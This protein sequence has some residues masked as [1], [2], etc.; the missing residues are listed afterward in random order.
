MD[1]WFVHGAGASRRSFAWLSERLDA[2]LDDG[3]QSV[4]FEH[5]LDESGP[6]ALARLR[7][8]LDKASAPVLLF[9]HSL[10]GLLAVPASAS[11]QV[12]R[13]VTLSAP[14]RGVAMAEMLR[15]FSPSPLYDTIRPSG[16]FVRGA[17]PS[18][19][20]KPTLSVVST[21]GMPHIR[22]PND[23]VVTV[24]SQRSLVGAV[25]HE[26]AVNHSEVLLDEGVVAR[27]GEFVRHGT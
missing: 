2:L 6:A 23:G 11:V 12:E 13:V 21:G 26:V 8:A 9:G 22:A 18:R 1:R 16:E 20:P 3:G 5:H 27:I 17:M 24:E 4:F 15:W 25:F 10:G 19:A 7:D 14:F